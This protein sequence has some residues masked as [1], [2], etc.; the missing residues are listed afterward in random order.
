[1]IKLNEFFGDNSMKASALTPAI[2]IFLLKFVPAGIIVKKEVR[3]E[4]KPHARAC[5]N[6]I[7]LLRKKKQHS[8]NHIRPPP[9]KE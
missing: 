1:M 4:I 9:V 2:V 7:G 8:L 5:R 3:S 6:P